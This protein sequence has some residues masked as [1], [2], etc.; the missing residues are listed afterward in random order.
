MLVQEGMLVEAGGEKAAQ[1][2]GVPAHGRVGV[3]GEAEDFKV[4]RYHFLEF[5]WRLLFGI[6]RSGPLKAIKELFAADARL[7]QNLIQ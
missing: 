6:I 7:L 5:D 3:E 1:L 4:Q 2:G